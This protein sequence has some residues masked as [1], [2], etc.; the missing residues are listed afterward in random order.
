M[1]YTIES[2]VNMIETNCWV[3]VHHTVWHILQTGKISTLFSKLV[4]Y[5]L[6]MKDYVTKWRVSVFKI[7]WISFMSVYRENK[8]EWIQSC[9]Q[10]IVYER[11]NCICIAFS[12]S[13]YEHN[14]FNTSE[15][16]LIQIDTHHLWMEGEID[17]FTASAKDQVHSH[18]CDTCIASEY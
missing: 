5:F 14:G 10:H 12:R 1:C 7:R 9:I 11:M 3:Y 17:W 4:K 13:D 8:I 15:C 2:H 16:I 6:Y 18:L